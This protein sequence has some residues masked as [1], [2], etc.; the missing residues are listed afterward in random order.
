MP[1][2]FQKLTAEEVKAEFKKSAA[3]AENIAPI[4]EEFKESGLSVGE[5][6]RLKVVDQEV[7]GLSIMA[8]KRRYNAAAASL[9]FHL[10]WK[11]MGHT[12]RVVIANEQGQEVEQDA[13]F[14]DWLIVRVDSSEPVV[15]QEGAKKRGR[16]AKEKEA[17]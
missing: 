11:E 9:G 4:V 16:P 13:Y 2:V 10:K 3:S 1:V 14:T 12:E 7:E 17:A 8:T 5:G 15:V 6:F